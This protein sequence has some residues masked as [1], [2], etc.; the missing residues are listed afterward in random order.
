MDMKSFVTTF[1][2]CYVILSILMFF[3]FWLIYDN[4]WGILAVICLPIAAVI[5][6]FIGMEKKIEKLE[7]RIEE[8][9][10]KKKDEVED[11]DG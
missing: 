10:G 9:E 6:G 5:E 3:G 8:L 2:L 4:I 7:Q 1:A 11:I